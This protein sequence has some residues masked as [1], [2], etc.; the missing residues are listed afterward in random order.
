VW[1]YIYYLKHKKL[2]QLKGEISWDIRPPRSLPSH[3]LFKHKKLLQPPR[4]IKTQEFIAASKYDVTLHADV[5]SALEGSLAYA[6]RRHSERTHSAYHTQA[7][8]A[9]LKDP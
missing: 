4:S 3:C 8:P 7:Y 5:P 2:L 1:I 9:L 6:E